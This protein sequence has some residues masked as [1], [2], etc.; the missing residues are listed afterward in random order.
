MT[1][2]FNTHPPIQARIAALE[3]AGGFR[4]PEALPRDEPFGV[5][6]GLVVSEGD[7]SAASLR[8]RSGR[9]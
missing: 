9:L 3:E 6:H 4:L 2:L 5:E 1:S 7:V 8:P